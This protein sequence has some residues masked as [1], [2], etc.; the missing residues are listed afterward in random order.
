MYKGRCVVC[1][2]D[3]FDPLLTELRR[4]DKN[5]DIG[6]LAG[7]IVTDILD[8]IEGYMKVSFDEKEIRKFRALFNGTDAL[9]ELAAMIAETLMPNEEEQ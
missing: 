1:G 4:K 7:E 3:L 9:A 5:S 6:K 2:Q 8:E